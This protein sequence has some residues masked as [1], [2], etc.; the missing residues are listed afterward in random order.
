MK[1]SIYTPHPKERFE[2]ARKRAF[3][4]RLPPSAKLP[5]VKTPAVILRLIDRWKPQEFFK[6]SFPLFAKARKRIPSVDES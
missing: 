4:A 2:P 1:I 5:T 3:E 6:I